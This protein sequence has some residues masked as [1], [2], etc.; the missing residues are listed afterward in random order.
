[1]SLGLTPTGYVPG[2][3]GFDPANLR[4]KNP[5]MELAEIKNGRLAMM[6]I[7]GMAIQEFLYGTPVV[8]QTPGF[9]MP[10]FMT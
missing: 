3:L 2:D 10:F 9:F 7:K 4:G 1:M 6:A 5:N 8:D